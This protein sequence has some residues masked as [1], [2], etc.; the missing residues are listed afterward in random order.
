MEIE[1]EHHG[2]AHVWES[3]DPLRLQRPVIPIELDVV[4][5]HHDAGAIGPADQRLLRL[6][7]TV[8]VPVLLREVVELHG[9]SVRHGQL[10]VLREL[11]CEV[12]GVPALVTTAA[13]SNLA[14][15]GVD[16]ELGAGGQVDEPHLETVVALLTVR[17]ALH[18]SQAEAV[19][20]CLHA[21]AVGVLREAHAVHVDRAGSKFRHHLLLGVR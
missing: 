3:K 15:A 11:R 14:P 13:H 12:V 8:G 7:A 21:D 4:A 19:G 6:A 9:A 17:V 1:G 2:H 18:E 5:I 10:D 20:H 16:V